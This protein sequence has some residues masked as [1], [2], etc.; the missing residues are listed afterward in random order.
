VSGEDLCHHDE[1]DRVVPSVST[2]PA[3]R[4]ESFTSSPSTRSNIEVPR[5]AQAIRM[6]AASEGVEW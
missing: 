4:P 6:N 3:T 2:A 5:N 1:H